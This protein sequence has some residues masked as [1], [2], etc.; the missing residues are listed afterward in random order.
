MNKVAIQ[1][2]KGSFHHQVA[3]QYFG[4]ELDLTACMTFAEIPHLLKQQQVTSAVMAIE[5]SIAGSLLPNYK[6]IDEH[7]LQIVGEVFL[8]I[9]HQLLALP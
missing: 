9:H 2:I 6:L 8:P 5:N 3:N 4:N 1:G 7:D